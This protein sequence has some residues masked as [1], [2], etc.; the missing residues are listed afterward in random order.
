MASDQSQPPIFAHMVLGASMCGRP[1][2]T[3]SSPAPRRARSRRYL[4]ATLRL[5]LSTRFPRERGGLLPTMRL[6]LH[7]YP[8]LRLAYLHHAKAPPFSGCPDSPV[9]C[10]SLR[11]PD[12]SANPAWYA[13]LEA[14]VPPT[15]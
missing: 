8:P 7:P 11:P 10:T 9:P 5:R 13:R 15:S 14:A 2:P 4:L 12:R 6:G 1:P 3:R